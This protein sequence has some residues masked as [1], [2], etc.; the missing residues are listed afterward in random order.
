MINES[1]ESFRNEM[2]S[3]ITNEMRSLIQSIGNQNISEQQPIVVDSPSN[4]NNLNRNNNDNSDTILTEKVLSIIRNWKIKFT[5]HDNSMPVDEFI[6]RVNILATNTLKGDF[7][8]LCRHAH[9][10]FEGKALEWY[11][12]FHRQNHDIDWYS[13][14][15]ALRTHYKEDYTDFDILDDIRRRKQKYNEKF[16][17]YFDVISAM[18][19]KLKNPI[20]D[21]DL[22]ETIIRNLKNEVRHELLHL[23]IS[24][25][26]QLRREVRKHEKF[27]K[28]VH[29]YESRKTNKGH[30]AELN[31]EDSDSNLENSE[32]KT[33]ENE[34]CG[35]QQNLTCWNC[36]KKGHTYFDCL[37]SKQVFCYGCGAKNIYKPNCTKCSKKSGN[38]Q[39]DVR[40]T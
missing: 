23:E 22:C 37:E 40:R 35:L 18:T 21:R 9:S 2:R 5:G 7:E 13:L 14:T 24:S 11:W 10:L 6:Y 34:I 15:N 19:D 1:L 17:E 28:D 25:V 32:N 38:Y 30:L 29:A 33:D 12:R 31:N 27:M 4:T 16:D 39:K 26:S 3:L 20:S 36:D 8:I